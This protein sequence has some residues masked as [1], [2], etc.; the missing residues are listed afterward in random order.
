[1]KDKSSGGNR[2][3]SIVGCFNTHEAGPSSPYPDRSPER[4]FFVRIVRFLRLF[5]AGD[6][7]R[8]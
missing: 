5:M 3:L 7:Y 2:V 6:G 8:F 4:L 1:M